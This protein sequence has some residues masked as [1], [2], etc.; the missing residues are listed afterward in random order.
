MIEDYTQTPAG[1]MKIRVT[2]EEY[3]GCSE[4]KHLM[5]SG[6]YCYFGVDFISVWLKK[7]FFLAAFFCCCFGEVVIAKF[8]FVWV[9]WLLLKVFLWGGLACVSME[10]R[11][12]DPSCQ[13]ESQA[14]VVG[15]LHGWARS[16]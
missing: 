8:K 10:D 6:V 13:A 9:D 4:R 15:G 7:S 2:Q 5:N 11:K 14:W 12:K 3:I 16:S 1:T